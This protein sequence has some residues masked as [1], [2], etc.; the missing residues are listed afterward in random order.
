MT[1]LGESKPFE[2]LAIDSAVAEIVEAYT[3][4][5]LMPLEPFG[6]LFI[7]RWTRIIDAIFS[8]LGIAHILQTRESLG[9]SDD[10]MVYLDYMSLRS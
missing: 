3:R 6:T 5:K 10:S 8:L 9:K 4:H 2:L 7:W 1:F